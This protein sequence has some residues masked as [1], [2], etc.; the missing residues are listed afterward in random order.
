MAVIHGRLEPALNC[1]MEGAV[2]RHLCSTSTIVEL[3]KSYMIFFF[4]FFIC[5]IFLRGSLW[6]PLPHPTPLHV[7]GPQGSTF[8]LNNYQ[9]S[10]S[11][12]KS[13]VTRK[14]LNLTGYEHFGI[15]DTKGDQIILSQNINQQYSKYS[16]YL[17][18]A[19]AEDS[20][21][22]RIDKGMMQVIELAN[23]NNQWFSP[24][25]SVVFTSDTLNMS[26]ITEE[27]TLL[28]EKSLGKTIERE[29]GAG[30]YKIDFALT[31][32]IAATAKIVPRET[33]G[34]SAQVA[35]EQQPLI[36]LAMKVSSAVTQS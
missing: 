17:K 23:T 29:A 26:H 9:M 8:N 25:Q 4:L 31:S 7:I 14:S 2:N 6:G 36:Q 3:S 11:V 20:S 5:K 24:D 21:Y 27:N 34:K 12:K 18:S 13:L 28:I 35:A 32:A 30:L 33:T 1:Q 15:V 16:V 10:N 22:L 19:N